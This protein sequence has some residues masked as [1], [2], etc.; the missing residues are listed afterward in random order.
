MQVKFHSLFTLIEDD[1]GLLNPSLFFLHHCGFQ[2]SQSALSLLLALSDEM[3]SLPM[4]V[5][6][7]AGGPASNE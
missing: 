7:A 4:I 3:K 5:A 6:T 1:S 2:C